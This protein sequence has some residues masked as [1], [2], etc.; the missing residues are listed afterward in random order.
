[1]KNDNKMVKMDCNHGETPMDGTLC[2]FKF[3]DY[4]NLMILGFLYFNV[5]E[6]KSVVKE[7][8][9]ERYFDADKFDSFHYILNEQGGFLNVAPEKYLS[10]QQTETSSSNIFNKK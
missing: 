4:D 1:M 8:S 2:A 9:R 5:Q 10:Y 3:K 6:K 7:Y